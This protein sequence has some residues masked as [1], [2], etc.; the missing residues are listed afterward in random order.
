MH[1]LTV[2]SRNKDTQTMEFGQ[3]IESNMRNIFLEKWFTKCD[4]ETI[5]KV[6]Q[7]SGSIAWNFIHFIF[8][9]CRIQ[10][11]PKYID[12]KVLITYFYFILSF[13]LK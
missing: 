3:L 5:L 13:F 10:E 6:K 4:G 1:L 12:T 2:A 8:I 9:V 11:I 7:S